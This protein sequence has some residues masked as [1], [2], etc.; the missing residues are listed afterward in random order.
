[1]PHGSVVG[2]HKATG[3]AMFVRRAVGRVQAYA[4]TKVACCSCWGW[5]MPAHHSE[6]VP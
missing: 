6:R 2:P 5:Q 3:S 1:M 4:E